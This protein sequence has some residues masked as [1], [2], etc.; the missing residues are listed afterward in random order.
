MIILIAFIFN[1]IILRLS[2]NE[3]L[4]ILH[5]YISSVISAF[6]NKL[7]IYLFISNFSYAAFGGERKDSCH[8]EKILRGQTYHYDPS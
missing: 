1:I 2:V 8:P 6:Y 7:S 3:N 5:F 4:I